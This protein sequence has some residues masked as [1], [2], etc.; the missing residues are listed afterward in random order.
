MDI[1]VV[2]ILDTSFCALL[3]NTTANAGQYLATGCRHDS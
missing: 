2:S 1:A 3:S